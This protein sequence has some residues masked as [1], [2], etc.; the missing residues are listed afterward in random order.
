MQ[1]NCPL[2]SFSP[3]KLTYEELVKTELKK[4]KVK[5]TS[6]EEF[7][8]YCYTNF[9]DLSQDQSDLLDLDCSTSFKKEPRQD[10]SLN[11]AE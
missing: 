6:E 8:E 9:S 3:Q 2:D 5:V 7:Y 10:L 11:D 1:Q 4:Y